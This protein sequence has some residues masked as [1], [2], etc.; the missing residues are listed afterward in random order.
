MAKEDELL[1]CGDELIAIIKIN[2]CKIFNAWQ[3]I[4]H[5]ANIAM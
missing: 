4:V 3:Y 2:A 5:I 1:R